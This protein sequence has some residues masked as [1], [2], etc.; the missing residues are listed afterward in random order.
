MRKEKRDA[1][2]MF[3]MPVAKSL[4][5]ASNTAK[6]E[7][8]IKPGKAIARGGKKIELTTM[9]DE[10]AKGEIFSDDDLFPEH[11]EH[12][13]SRIKG[14]NIEGESVPR[15]VKTDRGDGATRRDAPKTRGPE[16]TDSHIEPNP[17]R[18]RRSERPN[19]EHTRSEAIKQWAM[20][21]ARFLSPPSSRDVSTMRDV[22]R[23]RE[24]CVDRDR[25]NDKFI[26]LLA[27]RCEQERKEQERS[28][29]EVSHLRTSR[30]ANASGAE[31]QNVSGSTPHYMGGMNLQYNNSSRIHQTVNTFDAP[32]SAT[33][34]DSRDDN[35]IPHRHKP[36]EIPLQP[37]TVRPQPKMIGGET[38]RRNGWFQSDNFHTWGKC[39]VRTDDPRILGWA[40]ERRIIGNARAVH[41]GDTPKVNAPPGIATNPFVRS[42]ASK[43]A[44]NQKKKGKAG[45]DRSSIEGRDR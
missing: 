19:E 35:R 23:D 28:Q 12:I 44:R 22:N 9:K 18:R 40:M 33:N 1:K 14:E 10:V 16:N 32:S 30:S 2:S 21:L 7:T 15:R 39:T 29:M 3:C 8:E 4:K 36:C 6:S 27:N 38:D 26:A 43:Y 17:I 41:V 13:V 5:R 24:I 31:E 20:Q 34:R 11:T 37:L 42:S 25:P 45:E